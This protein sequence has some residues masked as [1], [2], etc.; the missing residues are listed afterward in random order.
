MLTRISLS[1]LV[2]LLWCLCTPP[3]E[4][5]TATPGGDPPAPSP[6]TQSAHPATRQLFDG[7]RH[8]YG[9]VDGL[10]NDI[11]GASSPGI[12]SELRAVDALEQMV[13]DA[14]RR[15]AVDPRAEQAAGA[16]RRCAYA[17]AQPAL[18][19]LLAEK[20]DDPYAG[21]LAGICA[22]ELG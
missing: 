9:Q 3:T 15:I 21:Y 16:M 13:E 1:G 10:T 22:A 18:G 2:L 12:A 19:R 14:C 4:S 11:T 5:A 7:L 6:A 8:V 17:D 20:P